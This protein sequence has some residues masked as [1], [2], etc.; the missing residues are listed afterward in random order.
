MEI[1]LSL[2]GSWWFTALLVIN[3]NGDTLKAL[4][5]PLVL[6][7]A[8]INSNGD[9]LKEDTFVCFLG[10]SQVINSNGDTLKERLKQSGVQ[11]F[12]L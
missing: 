11:G 4:V 5:L 6:A 10:L 3:S 1:L 2:P 7:L 12:M 8:V 9:T